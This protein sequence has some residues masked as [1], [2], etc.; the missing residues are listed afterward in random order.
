MDIKQFKG[1]VSLE[2]LMTYGIAIAIVVIAVAA[3]YSM[4]VFSGNTTT[5]PPCANCF[6]DFTSKNFN[7]ST[8]HLQLELINGPSK[9]EDVKCGPNCN[10]TSG[11]TGAIITEINANSAFVLEI[12]GSDTT[13][14][15]IQL[16][17]TKSGSTLPTTRTQ[18]I[19]GDYF[20]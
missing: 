8:G 4:G 3:L 5:A 18:P 10:V 20:K 9:I 6:S 16:N 1:Q 17:Y 12:A 11:E 19:G 14:T 13:G 15:S 2:Y 7:P